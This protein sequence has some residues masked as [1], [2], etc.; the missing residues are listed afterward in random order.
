MGLAPPLGNPGSATM[1]VVKL[2]KWVAYQ[3]QWEVTVGSL[4]K[5]EVAQIKCQR[6]N[7]WTEKYSSGL[8]LC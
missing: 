1:D 7:N 8:L 6:N 5:I 4:D 3:G 2:Q